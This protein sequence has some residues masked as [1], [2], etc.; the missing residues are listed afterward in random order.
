MAY[1][2][3]VFWNIFYFSMQ[4]C[5]LRFCNEHILR[6]AF[7]VAVA[8]FICVY[9]FYS[10]SLLFSKCT[11]FLRHYGTRANHSTYSNFLCC[12]GSLDQQTVCANATGTPKHTK[13]IRFIYSFER[14]TSTESNQINSNR[15][16]LEA[17]EHR[18]R[19]K[20]SKKTTTK[21]S[22]TNQ[23]VEV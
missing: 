7:V 1:Y 18:S 10:H 12:C 6:N 23:S 17:K 3:I 9:F 11:I 20:Y 5:L 14:L 19:E 16:K 22:W 4:E 13:L 15:I 2:G 21:I 8:A